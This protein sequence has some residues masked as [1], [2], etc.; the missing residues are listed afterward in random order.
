[1]TTTVREAAMETRFVL[2]NVSWET[3]EC[4]MRDYEDSS[5]PR[6]TYHKGVLEI[7][8]L[9]P[10]HE[11]AAENIS[12][13]VDAVAL[14][15]GVNIRSLRSTTWKRQDL[16]QGFEADACYYIAN[17]GRMRGKDVLDL[18]VDPPPDLVVEVDN[19]RSSIDKL[20]LLA[21][22][23]VPE[24]WRYDGERLEMR[25]LEGGRHVEVA[26]SRALRGVTAEAITKLLA[27]GSDEDFVDWMRRVREWAH[28]LAETEA[29]Q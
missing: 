8:R 18:R 23:G 13:L 11:E 21:A 17:A 15:R 25:T 10:R 1:M 6:F 9:R 24:V 12:R 27:E 22:F 14:E 28:T 26:E 7:V 4:L 2:S 5:A 19:T 29:G 3:Y 20:A 16:E